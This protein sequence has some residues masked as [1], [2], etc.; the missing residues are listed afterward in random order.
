ME[1]KHA[2]RI[3]LDSVPAR[4]WF[5]DDKNG[6]IK[7]NKAAADSMGGSIID[8]EGKNTFDLFGEMAQK[9]L[10]DDLKVINSGVPAL[11]IIEEYTP[12]N[13]ETGWVSSDKIPLISPEGEK[14]LLVVT[15]DIT[16]AMRKEKELE[17]IN[18]NLQQ[19]AAMASHD[20]KAPLRHI[21]NG[22]DIVSL[23]HSEELSEE[24]KTYIEETRQHAHKLRDIIDSFLEF[25][26]AIP[27]ETNHVSFDAVSILHDV[28]S[29]KSLEIRLSKA[30]IIIP[31]EPIWVKADPAL[32]SR[33]FENIVDN[34]IKYACPMRPLKLKIMSKKRAG[35][36]TA[37]I[38]DDNGVGISE[39]Q[40]EH[41][42]DLF[43]RSKK[44]KEISG[45]GIGLATCRRILVMC[46]GEI[47]LKSKK[48]NGSRFVVELN[49][50]KAV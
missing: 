16:D 15:T 25:A 48:S 3:V 34:A 39:S 47:K 10:I 46:N 42:F 37:I 27:G 7:L 23:E 26:R 21:L 29:D 11:G 5:K 40:Q 24:I 20:L 22:A 14:Q 33:V 4:I 9:Y 38:F 45:S 13:G 44:A 50:G 19:F 8:F 17:E 6:I 12:E 2:L 18:K 31:K 41:V 35:T 49:S 28:I 36:N 43:A 1:A 30:S 32:I